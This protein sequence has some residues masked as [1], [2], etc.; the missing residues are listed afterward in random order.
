MFK[1]LARG[2]GAK[3][4]RIMSLVGYLCF[5]S[6]NLNRRHGHYRARVSFRLSP[7][8]RFALRASALRLASVP[9]FGLRPKPLAS[10]LA[11]SLLLLEMKLRKK[12]RL[13]RHLRF[14][15]QAEAVPPRS[16]LFG[17]YFSLVCIQAPRAGF[18]GVAPNGNSEP[19]WNGANKLISPWGEAP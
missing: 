17:A 9:H 16:R 19:R 8:V 1:S 4:Q 11:H 3:P 5:G 7:P 15:R 18:W 12:G 10:L 2:F 13:L 14:F 6:R